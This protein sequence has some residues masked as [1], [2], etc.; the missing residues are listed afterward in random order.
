M[1]PKV[2]RWVQRQ[3]WDRASAFYDAHW[4]DQL[5]PA[6]VELLARAELQPGDAVL[7]VA[8]GT[9]MVTFP[10]AAQVAPSGRVVGVDISPGM[11]E[12]ARAVA[13]ERGVTN[14]DFVCCGAEELDVAPPLDVGLCSLG[15]MY[16]PRPGVAMAEMHR[17]LRPGGRAV[18]SVW[19]QRSA[20]GWAE[21][22]PIVDARVAS[23]VC[24]MFFGL[25]AP[26]ALAAA[27]TQAG[28]TD[29]DTTLLDV[30][31]VYAD[32]DDAVGAAF[33]GGPVA[34]AH[35]RFDEQTRRRAYA[36]YLDSLRDFR[37]GPG[38]RV[39]GQFVVASARRPPAR[40]RPDLDLS[41]HTPNQQQ[42]LQQ[43]RAKT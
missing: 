34:L 26:G 2:Q 28:F 29:V 23:D 21:I 43:G 22:F 17:V 11:I 15:L 24:P 20:C 32:D 40:S 37:S 8:C 31:L 6:H 25:G 35:S 38:Y 30:E 39:P 9:G 42:Q 19:G 36:E 5:R 10:A 33:L 3:G 27:M 12:A 13:C 41:T 1:E 14:T 16:M 4:R 7:D 18:V